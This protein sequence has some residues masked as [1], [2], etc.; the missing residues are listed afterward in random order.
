MVL[1]QIFYVPS[2]IHYTYKSNIASISLEFS[3]FGGI[4]NS[5]DF[6][7]FEIITA[8]KLHYWMENEGCS[9]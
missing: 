2:R 6:N 8:N 4:H 3:D 7:H 5:F 9:F 1:F